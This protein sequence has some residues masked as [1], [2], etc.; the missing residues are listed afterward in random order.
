MSARAIGFEAGE[1]A[2]DV[3]PLSWRAAGAVWLG[4]ALLG[5]GAVAALGAALF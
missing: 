1:L 4:L 5:W 3:P 2:G